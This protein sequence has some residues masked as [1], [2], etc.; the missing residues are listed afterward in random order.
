M[1]KDK[2][3]KKDTKK[4]P[5]PNPSKKQSAYQSDKGSASASNVPA[6]KNLNKMDVY[7]IEQQIR[8]YLYDL[9]NTALEHGFKDDAWQLSLVSDEERSTI[10][11]QFYP[12]I[13]TRMFPEM[14]LQ[15]FH[16]IKENLNQS[17][18]KEEQSLDV[19]S[20]LKADLRYLVA[21]NPKRLRT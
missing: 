5:N 15:V 4:A 17:L 21:Y 12:A 19:A 20:V 18:N 7:T 16:S 3:I 1:S 9:A 8:I 6:P 10:Q 11:R 2:K 14:I 13:V